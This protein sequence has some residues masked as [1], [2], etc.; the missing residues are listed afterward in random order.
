MARHKEVI[1]GKR[2]SIFLSARGRA[3]LRLLTGET[4]KAKGSRSKFI[5]NLLHSLAKKRNL[6]EGEIEA[7]MKHFEPECWEEIY[8][9]TQ[10]DSR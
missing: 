10:G 4:R 3:I 1:G 2:L 7:D 9:D 6:T 5:D 8:A